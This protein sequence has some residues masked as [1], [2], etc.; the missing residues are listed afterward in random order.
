MLLP[1]KGLEMNR[2]LSFLFLAVNLNVISDINRDL[3][4]QRL[5]QKNGGCSTGATGATGAKGNPGKQGPTGA[6]GQAGTFS[7]SYGKLSV[8]SQ[9]IHFSAPN[10]W[11]SIPFNST[12]PSSNMDVST[13]SPA[14]ITI[15]QGGVYQINF[16]LYFVSEE[17]P[18]HSFTTTTYTLGISIN[19][20]AKV[21]CAAVYVPEAGY[22]TL[23]Y[24]NIMEFSANDYIQF[25]LGASDLGAGGI[26]DN[27][28]ILEN[29][30]AYLMQIS[31]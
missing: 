4:T 6:T 1:K 10:E 13:T 29:G 9:S 8:T 25:Y 19:G 12:G 22:I 26:F 15:Q 3:F 7:A 18:E 16:S 11:T 27:I 31:N 30:N 28:V 2:I 20:G 21:A 17:S 24:S 14:T 23:N 5:I